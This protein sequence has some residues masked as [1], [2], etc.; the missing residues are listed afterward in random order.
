MQAHRRF[1]FS[2]ITNPKRSQLLQ[3]M[4]MLSNISMQQ[5]LT[6]LTTKQ[7]EESCNK[8]TAVF[9]SSR[10]AHAQEQQI[11]RERGGLVVWVLA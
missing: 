9:V 8:V 2:H 1:S 10:L 7:L 5:F 4:Q 6:C 3:N 11:K